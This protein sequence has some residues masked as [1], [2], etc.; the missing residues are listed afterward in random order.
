MAKSL[1]VALSL[2]LSASTLAA[3][4]DNPDI[5]AVIDSFRT[6]IIQRD[7][8]RFLN[9]FVS[10]DI[11]WQGVLTDDGLAQ[12]KHLDPKAVKVAYDSR[13]TPTAFIESIIRSKKSSEE[14]FSNIKIDTDGDVATVAFDYSFLSGE[15]VVNGGRECWLLVRT[16]AGWKITTIAFSSN[17]TKEDEKAKEKEK[18][19]EKH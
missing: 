13:S 6:A 10:P 17:L 14:K 19:K 16:G 3:E 9:L 18:E 15:K 5:R 12:L 2:C 4:P 8:P 11:P 1:L 7:K